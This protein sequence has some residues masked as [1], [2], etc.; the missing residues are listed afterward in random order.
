MKVLLTNNIDS[1]LKLSSL[2]NK[3]IEDII[4]LTKEEKYGKAL[5]KLKK[6]H[7]LII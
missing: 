5:K 7:Q 4:Q 1:V 2:T 3:E 6:I